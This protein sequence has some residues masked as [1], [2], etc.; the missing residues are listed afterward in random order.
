MREAHLEHIEP[1]QLLSY[2]WFLCDVP[3]QRPCWEESEAVTVGKVLRAVI[4]EVP[5]NEVTVLE[6][7][8]HL[9]CQTHILARHAVL[10]VVTDVL[11][12]YVLVPCIFQ[13]GTQ[14]VSI[15]ERAVPMEQQVEELTTR[16]RVAR[17]L[18]H[19][20]PVLDLVK[21]NLA[22][23]LVTTVG[24]PAFW[25]LVVVYPVVIV[26]IISKTSSELQSLGD[27]L[28]VLLQGDIGLD[29]IVP[30]LM[31]ARLRG[32]NPRVGAQVVA[33]HIDHWHIA[34]AI[35]HRGQNGIISE[36]RVPC[37]VVSHTWC[38]T[39]REVAADTKLHDGC[40]SD[41]HV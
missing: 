2:P 10:D 34:V 29:I 21:D 11:C 6:V 14:I 41:V 4:A 17:R 36:Q 30:L 26:R 35:H 40:R 15:Q 5:V 31:I 24:I 27:E 9:S 20:H 37:V 33:H 23:V 7:I 8:C 3:R 32:H 22:R 19:V 18:M 25:L 28:Q 39:L 16:A 38:V 1:R 12:L 13:I